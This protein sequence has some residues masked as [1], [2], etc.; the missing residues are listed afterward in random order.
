M[1]HSEFR[2]R[3]EE[4]GFVDDLGFE[5]INWD[6]YLIITNENGAVASVNKNHESVMSTNDSVALNPEV[7]AKLFDIMAE[8]AKTPIE[9][10][11]DEK[12]Y[13]I[14]PIWTRG[15][16]LKRYENTFS[17]YGYEHER[18]FD[19]SSHSNYEKGVSTV[20]TESEAKEICDFFGWDFDKVA[21]GVDDDE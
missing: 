18:S 4:L 5:V 12:K 16:R 11:K 9:D 14:Y 1:K 10:R 21:V 17:N 7:R 20:F 2:R 19:M 6:E 8:Y 13:S 15:Q 3:I